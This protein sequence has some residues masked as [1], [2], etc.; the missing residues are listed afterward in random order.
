MFIERMNSRTRWIN[1]FI[2]GSW[3]I[4]DEENCIMLAEINR[5][6]NENNKPTGSMIRGKEI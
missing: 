4:Y 5:T 3:D 2:R 6:I 1:R